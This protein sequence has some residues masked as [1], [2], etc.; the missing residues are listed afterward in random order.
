MLEVIF[1]LFKIDP[2]AFKNYIQN[3]ATNPEK[4]LSEKI[5]KEITARM[6]A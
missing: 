4:A 5:V 2:Q 6:S 3:N 1:K